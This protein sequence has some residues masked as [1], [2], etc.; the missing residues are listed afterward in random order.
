MATDLI[1][2]AEAATA[3]GVTR[4]TILNWVDAGRIVPVIRLKANGALLFDPADV[5]R[6]TGATS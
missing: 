1:T 6:L 2:T 3:C 4:Q 5:D